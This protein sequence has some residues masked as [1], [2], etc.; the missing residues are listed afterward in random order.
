MLAL[1]ASVTCFVA[2]VL[3]RYSVFCYPVRM[4][5]MMSLQRSLPEVGA[6]RLHAGGW[7]QCKEFQLLLSPYLIEFIRMHDML[8]QK[9]VAKLTS[10]KGV[11]ML[12]IDYGER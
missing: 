12:F 2:A 10:N 3:P 1:R 11:T 9:G 5:D 6:R 8:S 4:L 7:R